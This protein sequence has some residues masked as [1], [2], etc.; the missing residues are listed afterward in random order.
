MKIKQLI[1][2]DG[3]SDE[4]AHISITKD[5][6]D[7]NTLVE[8]TI[9]KFNKEDENRE[10]VACYKDFTFLDAVQLLLGIDIIHNN[11]YKM[12]DYNKILSYLKSRQ[13]SITIDSNGTLGFY[14]KKYGIFTW[15]TYD[16]SKF[17]EYIENLYN[18]QY[19]L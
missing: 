16:L 17:L 13:Q 11:K 7:I 14:D 19:T 10:I 8:L 5:I 2:L 12:F 15:M 18:N 4:K 6:D 3:E 1:I 9:D